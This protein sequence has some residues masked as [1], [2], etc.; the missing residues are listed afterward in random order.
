MLP[1]LSLPASMP[2]EEWEA[3][4]PDDSGRAEETHPQFHLKTPAGPDRRG[5]RRGAA[6]AILGPRGIAGGPDAS[7][8]PRDDRCGFQR[9]MEWPE[10][11]R[12]TADRD[13]RRR[14]A[15]PGSR[16][17]GNRNGHSRNA[18][19]ARTNG[20]AGH[21]RPHPGAARLRASRPL[22]DRSRRQRGTGA[23]AAG[24]GHVVIGDC[25]GSG[26]GFRAGPVARSAQASFGRRG[27]RGAAQV[28]GRRPPARPC[29]AWPAG[30]RAVW[31]ESIRI[32]ADKAVCR[33]RV[34]AHSTAAWPISTPSP[35][36][37]RWRPSQSALPP[38]HRQLAGDR[39]WSG[40]AGRAVAELLADVQSLADGPARSRP[41]TPF[42]S[43]ANFSTEFAS[44]H[45]MADIP[46]CSSGACWRRGC[47]RPT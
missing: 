23:V 36:R 14:A 28:D 21:A 30:R 40:S 27:G 31:K 41:Q 34:E 19:D 32:F 7:D 26:G 1:G 13:S 44:G 24:A 16:G 38:R 37:R 47:S 9:Q 2:D 4:G 12:A 8:R 11:R 25:V 17:A 5:A 43:S 29:P 45:P 39:A 22:G 15:G 35:V 33:T 18:R 20:G 42:R 46:A 6:L 10:A 3:L